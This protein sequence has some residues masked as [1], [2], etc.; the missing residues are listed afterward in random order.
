MLHLQTVHSADVTAKCF[1]AD[2]YC[3]F[4][5]MHCTSHTGINKHICEEDQK[6][7][8]IEMVVLCKM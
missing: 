3:T 8:A 2:Q 4:T 7:E 1:S 5:Q 6:L